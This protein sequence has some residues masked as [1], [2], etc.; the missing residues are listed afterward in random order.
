MRSPHT[1]IPLEALVA[2][3]IVWRSRT[4]E[5]SAMHRQSARLR[6]R[7]TLIVTSALALVAGVFGSVV[8]APAALADAPPQTITLTSG[9]GLDPGTEDTSI[10][11]TVQDDGAATGNAVVQDTAVS[12]CAAYGSIGASG[13]QFV[14]AGPTDNGCYNSAGAT[15]GGAEGDTLTT[16]YSPSFTL[17][18]DYSGVELVVHYLADNYTSVSLN[19]TRIDTDSPQPEANDFPNF[20]GT[21]DWTVDETSASLFQPG[22]N[23]L[24]FDVTDIEPADDTIAP[25]GLAFAATVNY[26]DAPDLAIAKTADH[27][28]AGNPVIAGNDLVYTLAVSNNGTAEAD[29]VQI[30]DALP[31]TGTA[32]DPRFCEVTSPNTSCDT[33]S[34]DP[35][36]SSTAIPAID[37][38]DVG[39]TR[40][41]QIGYEVDPSTS[42]GPQDNTAT[43]SSDTTESVVANSSDDNT[44]TN[45][46][47]VITRS[48]LS[49]T[50]KS[51]VGS[52]VTGCT[53]PTGT[54]V[55]ANATDCQNT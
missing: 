2:G 7:T 9:L 55:F 50:K 28:N 44:D 15:R 54:L 48:D 5:G 20:D 42:D 27:D 22:S 14:T 49:F 40:T 32:S 19:G 46:V 51:A 30:T 45:T 29:N 11:Y 6:V 38:L 3:C 39:E 4:S 13:A 37:T 52:D 43:V 24:S 36:D 1:G 26:S 53:G 35:Y 33:S 8:T 31:N 17:P 23:T 34:G 16:T 12:P 47:G 41:F 10:Q 25:T 18:D 21:V